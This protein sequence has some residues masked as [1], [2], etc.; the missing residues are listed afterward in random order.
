MVQLPGRRTYHVLRYLLE[1][2]CTYYNYSL[3][4]ELPQNP[5]WQQRKEI[6]SGR[7]RI[8]AKDAWPLGACCTN[9]IWS[10]GTSLL[11]ITPTVIKPTGLLRSGTILISYSIHMLDRNL[12][13]LKQR[14]EAGNIE[15]VPFWLWH[16]S[17]HGVV[18]ACIR[19]RGCHSGF[20][21]VY[22]I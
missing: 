2:H 16:A 10:V 18:V 15:S 7:L 3:W 12:P 5:Q 1:R 14:N 6:G 13:E 22:V 20:S 21:E 11:I 9:H 8:V 4:C 17:V 19:S